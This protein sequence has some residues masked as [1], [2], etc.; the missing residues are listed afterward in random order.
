MTE[1]T[2]V[3]PWR[4]GEPHREAAWQWVRA[5]LAGWHVVE[6]EAPPGDWCKAAAVMPA[7]EATDAELVV[8]HDADVWSDGL[9]VAVDKV[10][11]GAPWAIPHKRVRRLNQASTRRVLRGEAPDRLPLEEPP[12]IGA[13]TGG[14]VVLPR[15]TALQVPMDCRFVGYG[16]EDRSW[17]RA[18]DTL[19]GPP[20]RG[21]VN[22]VHL[23]HPPQPRTDRN[24][25]SEATEALRRRYMDA[26]HN[27]TAMR[28]LLDEQR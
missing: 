13:P 8:V 6:A 15:V 24:H 4:G 5:R 10:R 11:E 21:D 17:G 19:V 9:A 14:L 18:L 25:G 26:R 20:W 28:A 2:V 1:V 22:L 27:P 23:F 12:Y 16:G 3:V 7:I